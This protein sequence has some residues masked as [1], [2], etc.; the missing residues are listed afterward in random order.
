MTWP[1]LIQRT[2]PAEGPPASSMVPGVPGGGGMGTWPALAGGTTKGV[3]I[4]LWKF[5]CV[6]GSVRPSLAATKFHLFPL[7][8]VYWIVVPVVVCTLGVQTRGAEL[9]A[10]LK[11]NGRR[12]QYRI[13]SCR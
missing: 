2:P 4:T 5:G 13:A 11:K 10:S 8:S 6:A 12:C 9:S 3:L 7:G 1:L